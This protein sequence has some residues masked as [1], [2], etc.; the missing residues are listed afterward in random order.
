MGPYEKLIKKTGF[1]GDFLREYVADKTEGKIKA[2]N[3]KQKNT[4][5]LRLYR[6]ITVVSNY[7]WVMPKYWVLQV[8][9]HA[10]PD[11]SRIFWITMSI[12]VGSMM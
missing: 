3:L 5:V 12:N 2:S 8:I 4:F 6:I 9:Y 1:F 10:L 7:F 11:I